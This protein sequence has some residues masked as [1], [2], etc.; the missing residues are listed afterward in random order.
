MSNTTVANYYTRIERKIHDYQDIEVTNP[1]KLALLNEGYSNFIMQTH[2]T[3]KRGRVAILEKV[4]TYTLPTDTIQILRAEYNDGNEIKVRQTDFMDE[5]K[6]Y[7]WRREDCD[8]GHVSYLIQDNEVYTDFRIYPIQKTFGFT[9][10]T[11]DDL[12]KMDYNNTGTDTDVEITAGSYATIA[13]FLTAIEEAIGDAFTVTDPSVS[14]S[15]STGK[16]TIDPDGSDTISY[17]E[18]GSTAGRWIGFYA[19]ISDATTITSDTGIKNITFDYVYEPTVMTATTDYP[20]FSSEWHEALFYY[21]M[22]EIMEDAPA[23]TADYNIAQYYRNKYNEYVTKC[24][25]RLS[26][27]LMRNRQ[28]RIYAPSWV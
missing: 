19:D 14:Y 3:R 4:A 2:C 10:S 12:L 5:Y 8:D 6:G 23:D 18:L 17:T 25:R 9:I 28:P 24:K 21:V 27:G 11:D 20:A 26:K 13:L 16:I 15:T 22:H 1:Q 7:D